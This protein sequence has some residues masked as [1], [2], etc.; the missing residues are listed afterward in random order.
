MQDWPHGY[1]ELDVAVGLRGLR[2]FQVDVSLRGVAYI[3]R[4]VRHIL[5]SVVASGYLFDD[6]I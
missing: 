1:L 2:V 3:H 5:V 6:P 4:D